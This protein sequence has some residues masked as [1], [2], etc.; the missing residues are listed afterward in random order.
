M[1]VRSLTKAQIGEPRAYS[2]ARY[3]LAAAAD[4]PIPATKKL[5]NLTRAFV[6]R[7]FA[8]MRWE[9][10]E[11][12]MVRFHNKAIDEPDLGSL[13]LLRVAAQN[14]SLLRQY[15]G[16][17]ATTRR[18]GE[19]LEAGREGELYAALFESYFEKTNLACL[20]GYPDD[21]LLQDQVPQILWLL[22]SAPA[23]ALTV[24]EIAEH[25]VVDMTRWR[26][27]EWASAFD[28]LCGTI[29]HR[30]LRHMEAFGLVTMAP[31]P[32]GLD[33]YRPWP[34]RAVQVTPLFERFVV[35]APGSPRFN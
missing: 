29:V 25:M 28:Q 24:G 12:E 14:G 6:E 3:L 5:G 30:L 32:A 34:E 27:R 15:R 17:F 33:R 11:A 21:P 10:D 4:A 13:W 8:E 26:D 9:A 16:A 31:R 7:A 22:H 1:L 35:A 2:N 23:G 19:L 18:G 20:D